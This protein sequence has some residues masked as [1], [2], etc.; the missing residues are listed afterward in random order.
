[1]TAAVDFLEPAVRFPLLQMIFPGY[2]TAVL[3][4]T[5]RFRSFAVRFPNASRRKMTA[6]PQNCGIAVIFRCDSSLGNHSRGNQLR[7]NSSHDNHS[8]GD[9][10]HRRPSPRAN[11]ASRRRVLPLEL[12]LRLALAGKPGWRPANNP[13][14]HQNR[15]AFASL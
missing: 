12:R 2:A 1:M 3:T 15:D 10:P 8:R 9:G 11:F 13:P 5:I 4:A 7:C 14:A 6:S